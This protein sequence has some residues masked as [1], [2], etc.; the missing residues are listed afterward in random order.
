M[1]KALT[2]VLLLA[3]LLTALAAC[4]NKD[5]LVAYA[6]DVEIELKKTE[7]KVFNASCVADGSTMTITYV[8]L[9]DQL[10][11]PRADMMITAMKSVFTR[12]L[13]DGKKH[14]LKLVVVQYVGTE[15][16]L[17]ATQQFK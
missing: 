3:F 5:A 1:K 12:I 4:G 10:D 13:N 7:S 15:G 9:K 8:D 14:G 16:N 6:K 11:T 17:H 2:T